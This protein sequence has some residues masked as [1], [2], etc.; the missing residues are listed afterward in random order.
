ME[1]RAA[2]ELLPGRMNGKML[3]GSANINISEK[4]TLFESFLSGGGTKRLNDNNNAE[5]LADE[6][7]GKKKAAFNQKYVDSYL[8]YGFDSTGNSHGPNPMCKIC[9]DKLANE[10]IK[11]TKLLWHLET[12]H[13]ALRDKPFRL[14]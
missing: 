6:K 1:Y 4:Q 11:P 13:P 14:F 10:S 5:T 8:K 3:S 7:K 2:E 12:K 9:G